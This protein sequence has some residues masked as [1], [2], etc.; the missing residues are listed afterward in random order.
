MSDNFN[1]R[2]TLPVADNFDLPSAGIE[3]VDR[4][5]FTLFDKDLPMQVKIDD[6]STKVPVVFSTGERFAL[7][8]RNSPIRDRNNTIILPVIAIYRKSID[9]SPGQGGYGTPIA[10]RPQ[11]T[12]T[13]KKRLSPK[14]REYQNILNRYGIKS[15]ENVSSRKNFQHDDIFPG[16]SAKPG[17]VASRRNGKNLSLVDGN[18]EVN[19]NNSLTD[20]IFEI[21]TAP[22]PRFM[23][24]SYEITFW[25]QY[26]QNMN[27]MIEVMISR[28]TG[29]DVGFKMVNDKGMEYVAFLKTPMSTADNFDNFSQDE[30][31]IRYTFSV[32]VPSYIFGPRHEGLPTPFRKYYSAPQIEFGYKQISGFMFTSD[33]NPEAVVDQDKF[34]LSEI[35][36][37]SMSSLRRGQDSG[38]VIENITNPFT[39]AEEKRVSKVRIRNERSGETVAS[40]RITVDLQTTLDSP[41]SE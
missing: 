40:S 36:S 17:T 34:I 10:F 31:I 6:Q 15:Q 27:Q 29:Q 37:K 35:D 19:L 21:I 41:T 30:R 20:N 13:V 5:V 38:R 24:V 7:T 25:T 39:G 22:Y 2:E 4:A 9:L 32:D 1:G 33:V 8:R 26:V 14:D 23:V 18:Q 3:D 28:F 12:Y 16:N 11:P